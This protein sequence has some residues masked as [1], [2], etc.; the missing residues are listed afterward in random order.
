MQVRMHGYE[1]A[2][3][4]PRQGVVSIRLDR[5]ING[6][7]EANVIPE[8]SRSSLPLFLSG[9]SSLIAGGFSVYFKVQADEVYAEYLRTGDPVKLAETRK[10][11]NVSGIALGAAEIYFVLFSYLLLSY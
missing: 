3:V 10:L 6:D 4:D 11:D 7:L 5:A 1:T 9:A 2:F 8:E